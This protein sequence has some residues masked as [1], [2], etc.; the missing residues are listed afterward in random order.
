MLDLHSQVNVQRD[1]AQDF[2]LRDL[3]NGLMQ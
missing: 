3:K 1:D 2:F